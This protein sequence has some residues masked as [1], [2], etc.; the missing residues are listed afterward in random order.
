MSEQT[1]FPRSILGRT[2]PQGFVAGLIE[3]PSEGVR[4][5]DALSRSGLAREDVRVLPGQWALEIDASS[6]PS[7]AVAPSAPGEA[8]VSQE[9]LA[10]ALLG[11]LLVGI[12]ARSD[13]DAQVVAGVLVKEG[14]GC[15]RHFGTW[16]VRGPQELAE[17]SS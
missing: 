3:S 7:L 11:D 17:M 2:F 16:F 15:V 8:A 5:L 4:I 14:V 10:G 1:R 9:F 12:R 13:A 6:H